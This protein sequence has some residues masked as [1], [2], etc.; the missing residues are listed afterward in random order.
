MKVQASPF[1]KDTT[2]PVL[3]AVMTRRWRSNRNAYHGAGS[4][5]K[6]SPKDRSP[7]PGAV[8]KASKVAVHDLGQ[9]T[10]TRSAQGG[11]PAP[12]S[13]IAQ[14]VG[15][16]SGKLLGLVVLC[17]DNSPFQPAIQEQQ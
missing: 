10:V 15:A 13:K 2:G 7:I 12:A 8:A 16:N 11:G 6:G 3:R 9:A 17:P 5:A 4:Q 14:G 1:A